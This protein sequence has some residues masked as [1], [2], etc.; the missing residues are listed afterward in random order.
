MASL[1]LVESESDE[2]AFV[3]PLRRVHSPAAFSYRVASA[4]IG[5]AS[6]RLFDVMASAAGL[7]ALSPLLIIVAGLIAIDS[8]GPVFFYQRRTGFRGK[9][10]SI[11]KF[12]T[13]TTAEHGTKIT[14]ATPGDPR[15]TRVG[16]VLRYTSIDELPQLVNVL[17]GHMSLVGPRPHAVMHDRDF[18]HCNHRYPERFLARPGITGSAQVNG[19]RGVTETPEKIERR[20]ALDLDYVHR[21]S[22][23]RDLEI[24]LRTVGL[25]F[26]DKAAC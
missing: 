6:K 1:T 11:V 2:A 25:V 15:V 18:F 8:P 4:P 14:Q 24:L 17:L 21:W 5:G 26:G 9:P 20:L 3:A 12:R 22:F 10:F 13:M 16:R 19:A 7:V 23:L